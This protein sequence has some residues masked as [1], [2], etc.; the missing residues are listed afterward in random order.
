MEDSLLLGDRVSSL[1]SFGQSDSLGTSSESIVIVMES[2]LLLVDGK[3]KQSL[4][5]VVLPSRLHVVDCG[6]L[7]GINCLIVAFDD[8]SVM[9]IPIVKGNFEKNGGNGVIQG[10]SMDRVQWPSQPKK[11]TPME[12]PMMGRQQQQQQQHGGVD[13]HAVAMISGTDGSLAVCS[14]DNSTP[15]M[16]VLRFDGGE[17]SNSKNNNKNNSFK[18]SL[19]T[20]SAVLAVGFAGR[21]KMVVVYGFTPEGSSSSSG[22]KGGKKAA[23]AAS[24]SGN[25]SNS[26]HEVI[27]AAVWR[28]SANFGRGATSTASGIAPAWFDYTAGKDEKGAFHS[29]THL[30]SHRIAS[31]ANA[32]SLVCG[33]RSFSTIIDIVQEGGVGGETTCARWTKRDLAA[34]GLLF[35]RMVE[36]GEGVYQYQ[37][38]SQ[39]RGSSGSGGSDS[40]SSD[41]GAEV[42]LW[43]LRR[44]YSARYGVPLPPTTAFINAYASTDSGDGDGRSGRGNVPA[45]LLVLPQTAGQHPVLYSAVTV[46][47]SAAA[48]AGKA[49]PKGTRKTPAAA[50]AA[51]AGSELRRETLATAAVESSGTLAAVLGSMEEAISSATS[52]AAGDKGGDSSSGSSGSGGS[53][54]G[55]LSHMSA[56]DRKRLQAEAMRTK[57]SSHNNEEAGDDDVNAYGNSTSS[58]A[59][60]TFLA[61][62]EESSNV[63]GSDWDVVSALL[64]KGEVSIS[65]A[66]GSGGPG[67]ARGNTQL[68]NQAIEAKRVDVV[69]LIARHVPDLT[70]RHIVQCIEGVVQLCGSAASALVAASASP[71]A[72]KKGKGKKA[73]AA[74][75]A[76]VVQTFS[77]PLSVT[78]TGNLVWGQ[79]QQQQQQGSKALVPATPVSCLLAV[80]TAILQRSDGFFSTM[81][82]SGAMKAR[83]SPQMALLTFRAYAFLSSP[84]AVVVS[85]PSTA[86]SGSAGVCDVFRQRLTEYQIR[87]AISLQESAIDSHF[88]SLALAL[89]D[90]SSSSG[91]SSSTSASLKRRREEGDN[92]NGVVC[93][94]AEFALGM[95]AHILRARK[96]RVQTELLQ[97]SQKRD[98]RV[99]PAAAPAPLPPPPGLYRFEKVVF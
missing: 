85:T 14:V 34:G 97:L 81:M 83:L 59:A 32:A 78:T 42:A 10:E 52:G 70:E 66:A 65:S 74:L 67:Q 13:S 36:S 46:Q 55:V 15:G 7:T 25:D 44:S 47:Q 41:G 71:V 33:V 58:G 73:A 99:V 8:S 69:A 4:L 57:Q 80:C 75:A 9:V 54:K 87:R 94:E 76:A 2:Q 27:T 45:H 24:S 29:A 53:K 49:V 93:R 35:E 26:V 18:N 92:A 68:L 39:Q 91:S 64:R 61:L 56:A 89:R 17:I 82:L 23:A 84:L 5:K 3:T 60:A 12:F 77:L 6:V 79:Q 38:Q 16:P 30:Y 88:G 96:A 50:A 72:Q 51:P 28:V 95:T 31:K 62:L 90:V 1:L 21:D 43:S 63:L 48:A 11:V 19:G 86:P 20:D 40:R 98:K 22:R 37:Y